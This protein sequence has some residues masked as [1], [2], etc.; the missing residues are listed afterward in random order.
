VPMLDNA[1]GVEDERELLV[2][3]LG[4]RL[5]SCGNQFGVPILG[6]EDSIAVKATRFA[7]IA[8]T[9]RGIGP[10]NAPRALL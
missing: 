1:T 10:L 7:W 5:P 4:K 3:L 8:S 2:G 9:P 6:L